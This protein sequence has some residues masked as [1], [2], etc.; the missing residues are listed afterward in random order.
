MAGQESC[1]RPGGPPYNIRGGS[2]L[3]DRTMY[4][5]LFVELAVTA[6]VKVVLWPNTVGF[7]E[8]DRVE[9][10]EAAFTVY[11]SG[12]A[13]LLLPKKLLSV[14]LKTA[15][16]EWLPTES[17][18]AIGKLPKWTPLLVRFCFWHAAR[19][20]RSSM[21]RAALLAVTGRPSSSRQSPVKRSLL[22]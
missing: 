20:S 2:I 14:S 16:K 15:V 21:A 22:R 19:R 12:V 7:V 5:R 17:P 10:V 11:V 9:V 13:E 6:T 3:E 4:K 8:L 18:A 1:R